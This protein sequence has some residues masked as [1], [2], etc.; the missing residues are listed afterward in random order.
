MV[1]RRISQS[2]WLWR[3]GSLDWGRREKLH[4][5]REHTV[6]TRTHW[7]STVCTASEPDP[8]AASRGPP[9]DAG[10]QQWLTVGT[11]TLVGVVLSSTDRQEPSWR[12]PSYKTWPHPPAYRLP[13]WDASS[14]TTKRVGIQPLPSADRLPHVILSPQHLAKHNPWHSPTHQRDKIWWSWTVGP[15]PHQWAHTSLLTL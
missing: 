4:S 8:P 2:I 3:P 10:G 6:C 12:L 14:Q 7:K 5:W 1:W 11:L 9:A 13:G 15:T